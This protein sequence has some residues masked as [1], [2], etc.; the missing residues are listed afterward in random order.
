MVNSKLYFLEKRD[1]KGYGEGKSKDVG[2]NPR[3]HGF[4]G[5]KERKRIKKVSLV[6][7]VNCCWIFS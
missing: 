3:R 6:N 1:Y 7:G 2:G 4:V 5:I